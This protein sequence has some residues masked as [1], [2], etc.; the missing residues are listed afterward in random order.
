MRTR[1][2][3]GLTRSTTPLIPSAGCQ[4]ASPATKPSSGTITCAAFAIFIIRY[5]MDA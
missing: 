5:P 1:T 4:N 2:M 3:A